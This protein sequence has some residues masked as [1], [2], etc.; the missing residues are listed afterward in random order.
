[1]KE[2]LKDLILRYEKCIEEYKQTMDYHSIKRNHCQFGIC[3]LV[4]IVFFDWHHNSIEYSHRIALIEKIDK[5]FPMEARFG[6]YIHD[7]TYEKASFTENID[8]LYFRL[9]YLQSLVPQFDK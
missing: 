2:L 7:T 5:D 4:D 8:C 3:Y 1:M 6:G 9:R